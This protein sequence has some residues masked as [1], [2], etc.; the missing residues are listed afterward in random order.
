MPTRAEAQRRA[1]RIA[2][3][4]AELAALQAEGVAFDAAQIDALRVHHDQV[5]HQLT[6]EYDVDATAAARRMSLGMRV[7]A[8]L[9]AVALT[10]AV[11]AF[12]DR[13]WD[14]LPMWGQIA[15]LTAAPIVATAIGLVAGRIEK[16]RYVASIF[17]LVACGAFVLQTIELS[18]LLGLR[19]SPHPLLLWGVFAIAIATPWRFTL[20]F[21][22]GVGSI[23]AWVPAA[24]LWFA[25]YEYEE[26]LG[27]PEL[28]A[29]SAAAGALFVRLMPQ[30]LRPA[31]RIVV[32]AVGLASLLILSS[33]GN[34]SLLPVEADTARVIYQLLS[35]A[36]A[37]A[38]IVR[39]IT[40]LQQEVVAAGSGFAGLFLLTRFVDWWWDWMPKYLFFLI[41]AAAALAWLWALRILR[42]RVT[43]AAA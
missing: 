19:R 43:E 40:L 38:V 2:A 28:L 42:R 6:R 26:F 14:V 41:L 24:G 12:V 11:V 13:L 39:G 20:P 23:V 37:V 5:L 3:F 32:L 18:E 15:F 8:L 29:A 36:V 27:H 25:G 35:V 7:A 10:A 33:T 30:E 22:L 17:A 31:G 4:R 34:L 1:D 9:G 16:T 21:A